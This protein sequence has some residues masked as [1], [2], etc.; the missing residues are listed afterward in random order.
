MSCEWRVVSWENLELLATRNSP[1]A[2]HNFLKRIH[3]ADDAHRP[4]VENMR[5]DHGRLDVGM[6]KQGLYSTDVLS[7]LQQVCREAVPEAVR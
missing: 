6:S 2:T 7:R 3:W 5:V 4:L 1:L